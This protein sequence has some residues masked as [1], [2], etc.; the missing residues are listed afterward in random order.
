MQR[1]A[2]TLAA[3]KYIQAICYIGAKQ[4]VHV[5]IIIIIIN[6]ISFAF[7]LQLVRPGFYT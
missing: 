2:T 1:P 5:V 7:L 4:N 6:K 3:K